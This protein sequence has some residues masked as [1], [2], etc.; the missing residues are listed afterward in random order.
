MRLTGGAGSPERRTRLSVGSR[1]RRRFGRLAALTG[2]LAAVLT[3]GVLTTAQAAVAPSTADGHHAVSPAID[4]GP[5][6]GYWMVGADGGIFNYG[7]A[8]Y[9]GAPVGSL[10]A[11]VVG[12]AATPDG[13]GYWLVAADGGIFNYGDAP[14]LGSAGSITLNSPI[15]GMAAT[16]DGKGYWLVASD[17]GIFS[18]GDAN[19][20]GST[21]GIALA[22]PIVGMATTTDGGGYWLVAADG[23][24]FAFGD[25]GFHGSTGGIALA[26]PIVGMASTPDGKG[27]WL[28][29][30]DGGIFAFGDAGFHGSTG[31][32]ALA[33]PI[34]GMASTPDGLGYWLVA[35]DGG[36]FAFGD[37]RYF[38][39]AGGLPLSAPVVGMAVVPSTGTL[40]SPTNITGVSCPLATWCMAVDGDGNAIHYAS[41]AWSRPVLV[42][43]GA[44]HDDVG[45]GE[46]D[47]VSCPTTTF[48]MAVSYL[49]GYSLWNGTKWSAMTWPSPHTGGGAI[50]D[51]MLGVSCSSSAFCGVNNLGGILTFYATGTWH[52]PTTHNGLLGLGQSSTPISCVGTWCMYTDNYGDY[53]TAADMV[54]STEGTIPHFTDELT[55]E[56][57]C[58]SMSHC[59]AANTGAYRVNVWNGSTWTSTVNFISEANV[60]LGANAVSCVAALCAVVDDSNYYSSTTGT[61]W[62]A[63]I[64]FDTWAEVTA[65]SCASATFCVTGDYG[66]YAYEVNPQP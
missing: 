49:D 8:Q 58:T 55:T 36:I 57:S 6:G 3:S 38:G 13:G 12:M 26:R 30:S 50:A 31:G 24:I 18:F 2:A 60:N 48:C 34:V 46:F 10:N 1:S 65:V 39:S 7:S 32:I 42:D 40:I 53:Q 22:R 16:P 27:Y 33:R 47:G 62:S 43:N 54:L 9:D 56:V 17:G 63:P 59:V 28:V 25:A 37:A 44:N 4:A 52:Q 5:G 45:D 29:A 51:S 11:P 35:S 41:G 64:P 61:T 20:H 21:G 19:Y 66:G 23:G 14:Y 15:V